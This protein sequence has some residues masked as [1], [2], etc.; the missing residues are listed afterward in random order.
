MRNG[1]LGY[2]EIQQTL[3]YQM[4][5][6]TLGWGMQP[7]SYETIPVDKFTY[8]LSIKNIDYIPQNK[9]NGLVIHTVMMKNQVHLI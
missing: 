9:L 2:M 8:L 5:S 6:Y 1:I 7:T 4:P 3:W